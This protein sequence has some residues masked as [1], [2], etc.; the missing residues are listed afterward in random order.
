MEEFSTIN[1]IVKHLRNPFSVSNW[2]YHYLRLWKCKLWLSLVCMKVFFLSELILFTVSISFFIRFI[3]PSDL[4]WLLWEQTERIEMRNGW[5]ALIDIKIVNF[6]LVSILAVCQWI[7]CGTTKE[8]RKIN[9][10][11]STRSTRIFSMIN[12]AL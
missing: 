7:R 1:I 5:G 6:S 11:I 8:R 4:A 3:P 10:D 2:K 9:L 12:E